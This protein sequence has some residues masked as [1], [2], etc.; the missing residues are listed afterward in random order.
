MVTPDCIFVCESAE[1]DP[2]LGKDELASR[3]VVRKS[4]KYGRAYVNI[5]TL[6]ED[7]A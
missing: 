4:G 6:K 5:L 2:F 3:F 1:P 7:E